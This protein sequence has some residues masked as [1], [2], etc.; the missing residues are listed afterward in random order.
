M[1]GALFNLK[2]CAILI[3]KDALLHFEYVVGDRAQ[4][5]V[6][7]LYCHLYLHLL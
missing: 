3:S 5:G 4:F 2:R 6:L 1:R 7:V